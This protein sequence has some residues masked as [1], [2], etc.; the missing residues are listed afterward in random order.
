MSDSSSEEI[1]DIVV[2]CWNL[3]AIKRRET[4]YPLDKPTIKEYINEAHKQGYKISHGMC[5]ECADEFKQNN[6]N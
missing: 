6:K 2:V 4:Y 3:D 5:E 1:S